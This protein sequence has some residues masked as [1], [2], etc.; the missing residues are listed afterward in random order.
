[1]QRLVLRRLGITPTLISE[2][3]EGL[4]PPD[5]TAEGSAV[6]VLVEWRRVHWGI[7]TRCR[8][9]SDIF[10]PVTRVEDVVP[11]ELPAGAMVGIAPGFRDYIHHAA[12]DAT[13]FSLVVVALHL[14]LLN[15]VNDRQNPVNWAA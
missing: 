10:E 14:K 9:Q 6:L 1:N 15:R 3:E 11:L 2:E 7:E 4:V 5:R 8:I 13:V 12:K